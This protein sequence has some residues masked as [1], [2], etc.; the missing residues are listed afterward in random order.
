MRQL[1]EENLDELLPENAHLLC[2]NRLGL[3]LTKLSWKLENKFVWIFDSRQ[4]LIDAIVAGCFIPIWSGS[5]VN[6]P[7]FRGKYFIDGAYSDNLPKFKLTKEDLL[8]GTR[9]V[10]V[11]PF[12]CSSEESVE[13]SPKDP[14]SW[15][16]IGTMKVMGTKYIINWSNIVR[17]VYAMSL[18]YCSN[19]KPYLLAGFDDMKEYLFR[20]ELIKCEPCYRK[21]KDW[22]DDSR[23]TR[24]PACISCLRLLERVDSLKVDE[25]FSKLM[26]L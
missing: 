15:M 16:N 14:D 21:E 20:S 1:I 12:N 9:Q 25:E 11:C 18:I 3:S 5:P 26:E 19:Y 4:E 7:K 17:S 13:V 2:S 10:R 6:F 22:L 24:G 23:R 8:I